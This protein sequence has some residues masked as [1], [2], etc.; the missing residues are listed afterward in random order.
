M[1]GQRSARGRARGSWA[2]R[3][4]GIGFVVVVAGAAVSAYLLAGHRHA[5]KPPARL[6]TKV[7]SVQAVGLLTPDAAGQAG[8]PAHP[9]LLLLSSGGLAF[10]TVS[11]GDPPA[12][13]PEWTADQM[14]GGSYVFI[15][16]SSGQ[17]L[18]SAPGAA[19]TLQR[20]DLSGRQRW[21]RADGRTSA[22]GQEYGQ[23]RNA[24]DGRCLTAASPAAASTAT[25]GAA[26][27]ASLQRCAQPPGWTQLTAFSSGF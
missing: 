13:F 10:T 17:C 25:A 20:C 26:G 27:S 6:S 19:A 1:P 14:V 21:I 2:L 23:L 5:A 18:G 15:Y 9:Q 22:S 8:A 12:G 7:A 11:P 3:L 16:I 4:A 24:A